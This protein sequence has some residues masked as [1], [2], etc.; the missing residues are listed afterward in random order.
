MLTRL[1][2]DASRAYH[3]SFSVRIGGPFDVP[4]M[5]RAMQRVVNRHEALRVTFSPDGERQL[6]H[7][8]VRIEVPLADFSALDAGE[9]EARV[10]EWL[11]AEVG[12]PFDLVRGPVVRAAILRLAEE[13]HLLVM[14]IHHIVTDG[15]SNSVVQGELA[16]VY[17]AECQGQTLALPEPMQFGEYV[18]RQAPEVSAEVSAAERYWLSRFADAVPVLDLPVDRTRPAQKTFASARDS[19]PIDAAL[20]GELKRLSAR[21]GST[22]LMTL[23]AAYNVLLRRLSGQE[24]FIVGLHLAGQLSEGAQSL[25]GHCVNLLPLRTQVADDSTFADYL[26]EVKRAVLEAHRH[27]NY[28][29]NRL[30]RKLNLPRDPSRLPLITVTFNLDVAATFDSGGGSDGGEATTE[31]APLQVD[32]ALNPPGFVQWDMS[33]NVIDSGQRAVAEFDYN[34]SLFDA[35]TIRRWMQ[36]YAALLAAVVARPESTVGELERLLDEAERDQLTRRKS[37]LKQ[38]FK[39]IKRKAIRV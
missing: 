22:M 15:W 39:N 37:E 19:F 31:A 23:L 7:P 11:E 28:P 1:G 21:R 32:V 13:S 4:S 3:Q 24:D 36:S 12:R 2:D 35:Q 17:A 6:V 9:R 38:N 16:A 14:T 27:Q 30:L 20:Y 25:V 34:T 10:A 33:L 8:S 29:L 18:A 26:S 5:E